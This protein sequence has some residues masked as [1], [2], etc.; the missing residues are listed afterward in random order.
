VLRIRKTLEEQFVAA[1]DYVPDEQD[2]IQSD[3]WKGYKLNP[4]LLLVDASQLHGGSKRH[5][6]H[7][8]MS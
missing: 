2:F 4:Y 6:L 8:R 3:R 1:I 5:D 7:I